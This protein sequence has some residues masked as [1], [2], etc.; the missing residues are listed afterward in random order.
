MAEA[1]GLAASIVG[2]AAAAVKVSKFYY[3]YCSEAMNA[4]EDIKQL[5]SE[6]SS[7]ASLLEP[8]STPAD[9]SKILLTSDSDPMSQLVRECKEVLDQL[10][11]DLQGQ[12]NKQSDSKLRNRMESLKIN[13]KLPFKK[14]D[15][16]KR[17]EKIERLKTA[18][19][20]KLQLWVAHVLY[21]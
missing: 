5:V 15:T 7:L 18:V 13:L 3:D 16:Q 20:L 14:A 6:I 2:L 21:S 12:I 10:Q 17:I 11:G 8:L 19:T 9:A 1:V 4:R